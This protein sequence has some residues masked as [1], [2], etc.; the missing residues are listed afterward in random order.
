MQRR[1]CV[2]LTGSLMSGPV[3]HPPIADAELVLGLV[4]G[5]GTDTDPVNEVLEGALESWGYRLHPV[6]LSEAFPAILGTE[7]NPKSP[8]ATR[9]LQNMGDELRGKLRPKGLDPL[10]AHL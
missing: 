2:R 8:D 9:Q 10:A 4:Y 7:F 5:A 3:Q 6:H 1:T